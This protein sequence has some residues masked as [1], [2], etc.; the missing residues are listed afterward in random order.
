MILNIFG[1]N[2]KLNGLNINELVLLNKI[3]NCLAMPSIAKSIIF[4]FD[5]KIK[6]CLI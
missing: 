1:K 3:F 4:A 2:R 6:D 5:I